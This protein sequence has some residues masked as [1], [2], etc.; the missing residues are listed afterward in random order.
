M[1]VLWASILWLR[2]GQLRRAS[3]RQPPDNWVSAFRVLLPFTMGIAMLFDA[4][5]WPMGIVLLA[6]S[7]IAALAWV[8]G[9]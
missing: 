4:T 6:L 1:I 5:F 9:R 2:Y 7:G 3:E 8:A